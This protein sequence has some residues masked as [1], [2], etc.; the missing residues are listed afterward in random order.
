VPI[1]S[2]KVVPPAAGDEAATPAPSAG[3]D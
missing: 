1:L 3:E 2:M